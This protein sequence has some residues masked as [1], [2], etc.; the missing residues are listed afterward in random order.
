[1]I[2]M[3]DFKPLP[4]KD[5]AK[6]KK[7]QPVGWDEHLT[8][9]AGFVPLEVRMRQM[10]QN[11]YVAQF[12]SSDF[13]SSDLR[14]VWLNPDFEILPSDDLEEV[15]RK[16]LLRQ[17]YMREILAKK[18]SADA[19]NALDEEKE[20]FEQSKQTKKETSEEVKE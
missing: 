14:D 13:T 4:Y 12:K 1:M 2:T 9:T 15:E 5:L 20:T 18:N 10:E 11:G 17:Q 7:T 3:I 19:E 16:S 8:E 6:V